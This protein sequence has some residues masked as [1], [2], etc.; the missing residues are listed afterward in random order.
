LAW[1]GVADELA[2]VEAVAGGRAVVD[3]VVGVAGVPARSSPASSATSLFAWSALGS[4][5]Q[6]SRSSA[7]VSLSSSGSQALPSPSRSLSAWSRFATFG[8]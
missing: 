6:S 7:T 8:S 2:V 1:S 4:T 5:R 3:G